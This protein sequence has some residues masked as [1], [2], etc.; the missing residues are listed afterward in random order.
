MEHSILVVD[1][2]HEVIEMLVQLLGEEGY[3]VSSAVDGQAALNVMAR[4]AADLVLADG[5]MPRVNGVSLATRLRMIGSTM[6]IVLMSTVYASVD[7]RGLAF[8]SK[9]FDVDV[10]LEVIAHT[11]DNPGVV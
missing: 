10:L 5:M 2:D 4:Q 8:V 6:P 1:D 3:R 11:L 9:P 7:V